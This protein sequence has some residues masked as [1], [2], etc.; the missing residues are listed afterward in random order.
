MLVGVTFAIFYSHTCNGRSMHGHRHQPLS[1][2]RMCHNI[3]NQRVWRCRITFVRRPSSPMEGEVCEE[4]EVIWEGIIRN[5]VQEGIYI[6]REHMSGSLI[7][8]LK[9]KFHHGEHGLPSWWNISSMR[10]T[11]GLMLL[12]R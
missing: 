11:S 5:G 6:N 12:C 9:E 10:S 2:S 3:M 4:K 7:A 1:Y 8:I